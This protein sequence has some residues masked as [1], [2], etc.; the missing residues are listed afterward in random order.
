[1]EAEAAASGPVPERPGN[2]FVGRERELAELEGGLDDA[3]VGRGGWYWSAASPASARGGSLTSCRARAAARSPDTGWAL[4]GRQAARRPTGPGCR[5][6]A[7]TFAMTRPE[8][9]RTTLGAGG[10]DLAQL[11]PEVARA[12]PRPAGAAGAGFGGRTLPARRAAGLVP[13]ERR[14]GPS[15]R[16]NARR[17]AR[18]GRA[19]AAA[20]AVRGS[21]D[22]R[23]VT[24]W[25]SARSATSTRRCATRWVSA[26]AELVR[27]PQTAQIS[28]G[29][30]SERRRGRI[31][32]AL[33][34]DRACDWSWSDAIHGETEGNPLFVA[35]VVRL[36][37]AEGRIT[38]ADAHLSI[39]P[40]VR[41]VIGRRVARLSEQ[42][43][44]PSRVGLGDG[45]GVRPGRAG[46]ARRAS[47]RRIA[48][49]A[50]RGH[51]RARRNRGARISPVAF[52][53]VTH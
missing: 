50:G 10:P 44:Q 21:R 20:P 33:D 23:V 42:C 18:R 25:W 36:L 32:S 38:E 26:L 19:L 37:D 48:P 51:G 2:G 9:L 39:P 46:A 12:L 45:P 4:L 35:E 11:L 6:C 17:P 41:A 24:C 28:L 52:G 13:P 40:G 29:G 47:K 31:C 22:C 43:R 27:E 15:D 49:R 8:A 53:S 5:R 3:V 1:M 16:A 7:P 14:A 30:L 34:R